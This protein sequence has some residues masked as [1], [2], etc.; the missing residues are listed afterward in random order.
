MIDTKTL[1]YAISR[2]HAEFIDPAIES[3]YHKHVEADVALFLGRALKIWA[4]LLLIFAW[5]DWLALGNTNSFY[6]LSSLRVIHACLLLWLAFML[7]HK[8]HWATLGWP[9]TLAALAGYPLFFVYPYILPDDGVFGLAVM[10]LMLLSMYVFVP[11]RLKLINL[12]AAVGVAIVVL[13][14]LIAG[15]GVL[16]ISLVMMVLAWPV[17][18]GFAAAQRINTGNRKAFKLLM[19]A[20]SANHALAQEIAHRKT[21]EAELQRQALTDPLTGLSNRR[22]YEL[23]FRRELDRH[24]RHGTPVALGMIDLDHFKRINDE[25]GHEFGDQVLKAVAEALQQ[26]LRGCDI[27]GR[28]GG[29]EFI[30]IL[31]ETTLEQAISVAE[32]MRETLR[33]VATIKDGQTIHITATFAMTEICP[34]DNDISD[35][36]RRADDTLYQGKRAGRDRVMAAAAA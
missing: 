36:I 34:E 30:L 1:D 33:S 4:F 25:H 22:Q 6:I 10:M 19:N 8:P 11:N 32:R 28:F 23:L 20:Q 9:V 24:K 31:P 26:P 5:T 3:A 12:I 13:N 15:M 18:L 14:M 16:E 17:V 7:V 27:L 29:E 2:W 21:L 35:I